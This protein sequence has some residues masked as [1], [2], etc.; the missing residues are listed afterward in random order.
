VSSPEATTRLPPTCW[1]R[2]SSGLCRTTQP[3]S[4]YDICRGKGDPRRSRR[5][6]PSRACCAP[7]A[8]LDALVWRDLR[9]LLTHPEHVAPAWPARTAAIGCRRSVR[10]DV[11]NYAG[12]SSSAS[13]S[14]NA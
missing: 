4:A 12:V 10:P 13:G 7:A 8:Q 3:G 11:S 5:D 9:E 1:A 14:W 2:R 6:E